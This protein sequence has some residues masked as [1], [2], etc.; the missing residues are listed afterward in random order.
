MTGHSYYSTWD[1]RRTAQRTLLILADALDLTL[2][3]LV[4][5]LFV[6][7]QRKP[8]A[9]AFRAARAMSQPAR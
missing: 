6:P 7:Q 4:E 3:E 9:K 1:Q 5:G 2:D 8:S